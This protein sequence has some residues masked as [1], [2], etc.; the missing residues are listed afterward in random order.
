MPWHDVAMVDTFDL[1][2]PNAMQVGEVRV[3]VFQFDDGFYAI[4]DICAHEYAL[5]S[6]G[7]CEDGKVVCPFNQ[8]Y[9]DIRTGKALSEPTELGAATQPT[10]VERGIV[11]VFL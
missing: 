6:E 11:Q 4:N 1:D 3:A 5:L 2:K 7:F 10:L 9:F 8:A